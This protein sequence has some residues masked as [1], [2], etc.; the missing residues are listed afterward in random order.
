MA[1]QRN[2]TPFAYRVYR[3]ATWVIWCLAW[4]GLRVARAK[5]PEWRERLGDVPDSPAGSIWV[6]AASVGEFGAAL[7]LVRELVAQ[8]HGVHVTVV[9]P[10]GVGIARESLPGGV[11][12]SFAPLDLV[13]A[14]RRAVRTLRPS[15]IILIENELWPNLLFEART[16]GVPVAMANA[17]MSERSLSRYRSK[18]S[19]LR[20]VGQLIRAAV[21]QSQDDVRRFVRLGFERSRVRSFG[22]TK[23]D[24]LAEP[25]SA[26]ER[27]E[28]R[29]SFGLDESRPVLVFGSVR[30]REE[31]EI[32]RAVATCLADLGD[33]LAVV[34]PRHLERVAPLMT[35]L[36]SA[37]VASVR[38]TE[39][40]QVSREAGERPGAV[41]LDTTGELGAVYAIA[42]VAFVGGTLA[43]YGGHNPLEPAAQ[44]VPVALGPHTETCRESALLLLDEGAAVAVSNGEE[45]AEELLRIARDADVR[46]SMS[47][48]ALRVMEE[49]RGASA[50][51]VEWL[52]GLGLLS[53]AG[54]E[55]GAAS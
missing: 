12:V 47:E 43:N 4:P 39:S 24:L 1:D 6:H 19:P 36:E 3:F 33:A 35:A 9:T 14:V 32:V 34:A 7:P 51:A 13:P 27:E 15:L 20:G 21:C 2:W 17:R 23:F 26:S 28:L 54:R 55:R 50:R 49:G 38:R 5:S 53:N 42:N 16:H 11:R 40:S 30:P 44:G 10:A 18:G 8:G 22:S 52:A 37:G 25:L 41:V 46:R 29:S 31:A 45:L 48:A